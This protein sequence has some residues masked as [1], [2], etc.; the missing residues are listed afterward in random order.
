MRSLFA[1]KTCGAKFWIHLQLRIR[2]GH[3]EF[4]GLIHRQSGRTGNLV[5]FNVCA[6]GESMFE[7]SL[8]G[9][10]R[11]AYTGALTALKEQMEG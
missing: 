6:L 2:L 11:G 8:F 10:V 5:A 7:D 3:S 1:T 9:H 4:A